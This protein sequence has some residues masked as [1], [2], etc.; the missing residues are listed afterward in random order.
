MVQ[1]EYLYSLFHTSI[2]NLG[3]RKIQCLRNVHGPSRSW[4]W[5]PNSIFNS[6]LF[7]IIFQLSERKPVQKMSQF[8]TTETVTLYYISAFVGRHK[9]TV[10]YNNLSSILRAKPAAILSQRDEIVFWHSF[11]IIYCSH[12]VTPFIWRLRQTIRHLI[13]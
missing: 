11:Q 9:Q 7:P 1:Y 6:S 3:N 4:K 2:Y 5:K 13:G 8:S 12:M 10:R